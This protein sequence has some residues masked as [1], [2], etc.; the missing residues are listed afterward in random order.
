MVVQAAAA[1]ELIDRSPEGARKAM[2]EVQATGAD[3][4]IE[5]RHMLGLMRGG[6]AAGLRP[7]P[8]LEDVQELIA[9]EQSAGHSVTLTVHGTPRELP[10]GLALSIFRIVQESL[11]N[12]RKHASG[13]RCEVAITYTPIGLEVEVVDDGV[14]G[15]QLP[16]SP[17]FGIIGMCERA[18]LYGGG[19]EAGPRSPDGGWVVRGRFPLE[20]HVVES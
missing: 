20:H 11:T 2:H 12:V 14:G 6:D 5:M 15:A 16:R 13:S 17:G 1:A 4:M 18:R 10:R 19:L 3:A 7:Q 9:A 8:A